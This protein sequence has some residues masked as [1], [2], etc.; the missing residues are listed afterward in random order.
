MTATQWQ[1]L[2]NAISIYIEKASVQYMA[3]PSELKNLRARLQ[4]A[5]L[6]MALEDAWAPPGGQT[7]VG[8]YRK[9]LNFPAVLR[10][11]HWP[12]S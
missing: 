4:R 12:K 5:G 9:P 8:R 10:S 1:W 3:C 11:P 2:L 7:D 6:E